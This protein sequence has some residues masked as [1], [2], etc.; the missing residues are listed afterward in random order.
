MRL[1]RAAA[2]GL[3]LLATIV[4]IPALLGLTI[5]NP[6]DAWPALAAGDLSDAVLI[7]VLAAV[8]YLAWAQFAAA[9]V[10]ELVATVTRIRVPARVPFVFAGQ[11]RLAHTLVAATFLLGPATTSV[12]TPDLMPGAVTVATAPVNATVAVVVGATQEPSSHG[13]PR[14]APATSAPTYTIRPNGPG[15]YWDLAEHFL[16]DGQRWPEIW[17]LNDGRHQDD[18]AVMTSPGLLRPGWTVLIPAASDTQRPAG[19][20]DTV[21]VARGDSL[22]SI[23]D[24]H[25]GDGREW[26]NLFRRNK[27]I[28][29]PDG[30]RLTDPDLIR[31]GWTLALPDQEADPAT[32][33]L[34]PP[35]SPSL[36]APAQEGSASPGPTATTA[37]PTTTAATPRATVT[38]TTGS[39]ATLRP[40]DTP[41]QAEDAPAIPIVGIDLPG[42]WI[43][44]PLGAAISAAAAMVWIRRRQRHRY[45]PLDDDPDTDDLDDDLLG[46]EDDADLRPLPAVVD[47]VRR[48]IREQLPGLLDPPAPR[49]TVASHLAD[50]PGIPRPPSGPTGLELADLADL[51]PPRGLGLTGIGAESAARA[52]VVAVLTA[53]GTHDPDAQGTLVIP[54]PTLR[55]LLDIDAQEET[56]LCRLRVVE[57]L[58]HAL[59]LLDEAHLERQR[60]LDEHDADHSTALLADP[61]TPPMPQL[62]LVA[63]A[64]ADDAH[65]QRLVALLEQGQATNLAAVLLGNWTPGATAS[66][67]ADGHTRV[68]HRPA[69]VA[70]L[71]QPTTRDLLGVITEAQPDPEPDHRP[72][73][74]SAGR[75][76]DYLLSSDSLRPSVAASGKVQ[77]RVFGKVAVLDAE[78]QPVPGLR[79]HAAGLLTYLATHRKGADKNDILEAIWPDAP[80]RR[81]AERLSTEVGNLRRCIRLAAP[82][83]KEQPVVNTGGRYHVNPQIVDVDLWQFEDAVHHA[84]SAADAAERER[85]LHQAVSSFAPELARGHDYHWLEPVREQLRR[86]AIRVYLQLADLVWANSPCEAADLTQ[87]AASLDAT[88][89]DLARLAIQAHTRAGDGSAVDA[90]LH[91]LEAAL[92]EIGE[93]PSPETLSLAAAAH[94]GDVEAPRW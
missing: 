84:A 16:G 58:D 66:I 81:A 30:G 15:T 24:E 80:L 63:S 91:R 51:I 39:P 22:W 27:N 1:L 60:I 78:G 13:Q 52:L 38:A 48:A 55:H 26:P 76:H 56:S 20:V 90:Q 46:D 89:E 28:P 94:H 47:R 37:T 49:P 70:V 10:A 40:A 50:P 44:M 77:L 45:L 43:G 36:P 74:P 2:A 79:Q 83:E 42:G 72:L 18:G 92:R 31:P 69:R 33:A 75:S 57:N 86:R 6:L 14:G 17:H 29:Q 67:A 5:G 87:S 71:D 35:V 62:V 19:R 88:S 41:P 64:P 34:R 65:R 59:D 4:G 7:D 12:W 82:E 32:P 54:E 68:A 11:R 21:T 25:L 93:T 8:A 73:A 3:L 9:V 23:A 61:T 53:G 85:M